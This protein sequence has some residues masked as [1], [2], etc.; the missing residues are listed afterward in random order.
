MSL[1]HF[2]FNGKSSGEYGLLVSGLRHYGTPTRNVEKI[3]VVGRNGEIIF[4]DGTYTNYIAVYEISIIHNFKV[5][6]REIAQWLLGSRGYQKLS[7]T[8]YPNQFRYAV[9]HSNI[10]YVVTALSKEGQATI[11]F[12]CMPQR[13]LVEGET[14][15]TLSTDGVISN[16]SQMASKPLLRVYGTGTLQVGNYSL[17][18]NSADTYTD[19][20]CELMQCYKGTTNCNNNVEVA[21]FPVLVSG[22]NQITL[23]EGITKVDITPR[24]WIL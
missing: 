15:T 22:E 16:P 17:T 13:F 24:W 20:D 21:D 8:Y 11:E 6:A 5:N 18:I 3:Q 2:T 19:I 10:D 14:I 9:C 4:D 7:D 12:D 23:G 1:N